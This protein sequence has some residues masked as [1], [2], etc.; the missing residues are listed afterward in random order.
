MRLGVAALAAALLVVL[1]PFR[2][3]SVPDP[4]TGD[5][6]T[7]LNRLTPEWLS[8][9]IVF[10]QTDSGH[11][12]PSV[13]L[14]R[15]THVDR[16]RP[17]S[18]EYQRTWHDSLGRETGRVAATVTL[19]ADSVND[20]PA[21]RLVSRN[22]GNRNGRAL[23]TVDSVFVSRNELRLLRRT[24]VE[25]PYS[26]YDE[27]RIVQT[28][29]GDSVVGRMN[30]KG[31]DATPTGRPIARRLPATSRPYIVDAFAPVLLGAVD[32]DRT[33]AAR[34]SMV[35][36]AVVDHDVLMPVE[37]RVEGDEKLLV[38]AGR[39]DCWRI[40]IRYSGRTMS[41]WARKSDGVGV[42]TLEQDPRTRAKR[43][44]VLVRE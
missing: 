28:Y 17:R 7:S 5:V 8:M 4:N 24:A 15:F 33:W 12:G 13:P 20:V 3:S 38:P 18:L 6:A 37:L 29:R 23:L 39:F 44:V 36:W 19:A 32:L 9:A 21:W 31:A 11:D 30:V 43:E 22:S 35:G 14:I 10:A 1:L 40:G 42:R 2:R 16:L 34:A 41:Y 26:R 27:I 25:Q